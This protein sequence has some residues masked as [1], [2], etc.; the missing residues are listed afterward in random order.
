MPRRRNIP[1]RTFV[2]PLLERETSEALTAISERGAELTQLQLDSD[3][4]ELLRVRESNTFNDLKDLYNTKRQDLLLRL[5]DPA[6]ANEDRLGMIESFAEGIV[7]EMDSGLNHLS[8]ERRA[9]FNNFLESDL[10]SLK[11]KGIVLSR[12]DELKKITN[13]E[14]LA[15]LEFQE[16]LEQGN[17]DIDKK[18]NVEAR[19]QEQFNLGLIDEAEL[20]FKMKKLDSKIGEHKILKL[21]EEVSNIRL[22]S[23]DKEAFEYLEDFKKSS[24]Y[25][26]LGLKQKTKLNEVMIRLKNQMNQN[27]SIIAKDDARK[28][29]AV[30][31][32]TFKGQTTISDLDKYLIKASNSYDKAIKNEK[33]ENKRNVLK[34]EKR[35][36]ELD[37]TIMVDFFKNSNDYTVSN[38][39]VTKI[40][41]RV[42]GEGNYTAKDGSITEEG[43][44][45][46]NIV[47]RLRAKYGNFA[48]ENGVNT[49]IQDAVGVM[50]ANKGEGGELL[51]KELRLSG[52]ASSSAFN[53]K[54]MQVLPTRHQ[55]FSTPE[56]LEKSGKV[57]GILQ[58]AQMRRTL[59][60]DEY[61]TLNE[62]ETSEVFDY[63]LEIAGKDTESAVRLLRHLDEQKVITSRADNFGPL[64]GMLHY[65]MESGD[66]T[67]LSNSM[68]ALEII[69]SKDKKRAAN[70]NS[71]YKDF[72]TAWRRLYTKEEYDKQIPGAA[73]NYANFI[74][75]AALAGAGQ[76]LALNES[77][78][79]VMSE[80]VKDED[81]T[82][83]DIAG[84]NEFL[85]IAR[86]SRMNVG[87]YSVN[88]K[89]FA[90]TTDGLKVMHNSLRGSQV[91]PS[92][93]YTPDGAH[94]DTGMRKGV[95]TIMSAGDRGISTTNDLERF[96]EINGYAY[97]KDEGGN[98]IPL[99]VQGWH[100]HRTKEQMQ[101]YD[102]LVPKHRGF[103]QT[104]AENYREDDKKLKI[105]FK[106]FQD[107]ISGDTTAGNIVA[108]V[109]APIRGLVVG[110]FA[111][112]RAVLSEQDKF[113][114]KLNY[115]KDY[116][117]INS[118]L[119]VVNQYIEN[120]PKQE[121]KDLLL[122]HSNSRKVH[123]IT[124]QADE[125]SDVMGETSTFTT[126]YIDKA[127]AMNQDLKGVPLENRSYFVL[128]D[129]NNSNF[130]NQNAISKV[131][132]G[133]TLELSLNPAIPERIKL[134]TGGEDV[135]AL[136][137]TGVDV[138]ES[139]TVEGRL[140]TQA[141]NDFLRG[142]DIKKIELV[143][144]LR[145]GKFGRVVGD[146]R[147]NGDTLLSEWLIT[148]GYGT[149]REYPR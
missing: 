4:N 115:F 85:K 80:G 126:E 88:K 50:S 90:G 20:K 95:A 138:S 28:Y 24:V 82:L 38:F 98:S 22:N 70:A 96:V 121:Q 99:K 117:N 19:Y 76:A 135:M 134:L 81:A 71:V 7:G 45:V 15:E 111:L 8:T 73:G 39:D 55:D 133:D 129:E 112:G 104:I 54:V 51:F 106:A 92:N 18:N 17:F 37:N 142:K 46:N 79:K 113:T 116:K 127:K 58:S 3:L 146:L 74:F 1:R 101:E 89:E 11:Y 9:E 65:S 56:F 47:N 41:E 103:L 131:R 42:L 147:I 102:K 35:A 10:T 86:Q 109:L 57:G 123:E 12:K 52:E 69:N 145:T 125:F 53:K 94:I 118:G 62:K 141:V 5:S 26:E 140:V 83:N 33:N 149:R 148:K 93:Y 27:S 23:G 124:L 40:G 105:P 2:S 128:K 120:A 84:A 91:G 75:A 136:R 87:D 16:S 44:L 144:P 143:G 110:Y 72:K 66:M 130:D 114:A 32:G 34:A 77:G 100:A 63:A 107:F 64:K 36:L 137:V 122:Q 61:S 68:R 31:D 21:D 139:K 30:R 132:D 67:F 6:A 48:T 13:R 59:R 119:M 108:G 29:S 43:L 14:S 78:A 25:E 49:F 97:V 60:G